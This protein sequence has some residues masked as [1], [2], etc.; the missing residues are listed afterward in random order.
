MEDSWP[1][2]HF[3]AAG[4]RPASHNHSEDV[5]DF[6]GEEDIFVGVGPQNQGDESIGAQRQPRKQHAYWKKVRHVTGREEWRKWWQVPCRYGIECA[7]AKC[8]FQHRLMEFEWV[9]IAPACCITPGLDRTIARKIVAAYTTPSAR[10][11]GDVYIS[12][13]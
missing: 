11:E 3:W 13:D 8:C 6:K 7:R 4:G 5:S 2:G 10:S 12:C 9:T 1:V